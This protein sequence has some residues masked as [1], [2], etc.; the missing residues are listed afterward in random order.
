MV[1]PRRRKGDARRARKA[2]RA[3][4]RGGGASALSTSLHPGD[5]LS[6]ALHGNRATR[7]LARR[8]LKKRLRA[9]GV[10]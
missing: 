8:N 10:L 3:S 5:L 4:K 9:E 1:K 2:I 7:R 6:A